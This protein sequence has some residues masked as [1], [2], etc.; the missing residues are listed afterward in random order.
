MVMP[1]D[2][3]LNPQRASMFLLEPEAG[4]QQDWTTGSI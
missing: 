1:D 4:V 3:S 2:L